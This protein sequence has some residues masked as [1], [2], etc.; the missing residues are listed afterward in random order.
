MPGYMAPEVFRKTGHGKP[1]DIWALG[2]IS[3][4]LCAGY[5]PFDRDKYV[6][7]ILQWHTSPDCRRYLAP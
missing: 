3:Y 4:F 6:E 2:V 7:R 5:T 1:V